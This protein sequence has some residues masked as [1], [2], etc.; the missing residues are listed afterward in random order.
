VN[1][2][3]VLKEIEQFMNAAWDG[4]V[5]GL[6][7]FLD[8]YPDAVE[9]T[10]GEP[11]G[12]T[13]LMWAA[14]GGSKDSID[15]LLDRGAK[16]EALDAEGMTPLMLAG[17]AGSISAVQV[18]LD[19]GA[20]PLAVDNKGRT[21]A[22]CAREEKRE[23]TATMLEDAIAAKRQMLADAAQTAAKQVLNAE[24]DLQD[25]MRAVARSGKFRIRSALP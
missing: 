14:R 24:Q 23:I 18:L 9:I 17:H 21:A 3:I 16:I 15:L 5:K 10:K 22:D 11:V 20:D 6:G 12:W 1:S 25:R 4:D 2:A 8:K 13:A 7:T 19:R